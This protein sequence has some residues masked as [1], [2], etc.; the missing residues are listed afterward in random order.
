[1]WD[2]ELG[3]AY[4]REK[5]IFKSLDLLKT[6]RKFPLSIIPV[7]RFGEQTPI[8][9]S[10][11][12]TCHRALLRKL[13]TSYLCSNCIKTCIKHTQENISTQ[14]HTYRISS[15]SHDEKL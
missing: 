1:M 14:T 4:R 11:P 3:V 6:E 12:S 15:K 2:K 9:M 10:F 8:R 13:L 7:V 5:N